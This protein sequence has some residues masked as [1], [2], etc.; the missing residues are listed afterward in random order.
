MPKPGQPHNEWFREYT[1]RLRKDGTCTCPT[2]G[3]QEVNRLF[4]WG[5]YRN[6]KFRKVT[7][8]C[9]MCMEETVIQPLLNHTTDCHCE[10]NFM[11]PSELTTLLRTTYV[12]AQ[13]ICHA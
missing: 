12:Q 8:F 3:N 11:G 5:E 7:E 9:L 10:I 2:C 1:P 4:C 6:A 13:Q